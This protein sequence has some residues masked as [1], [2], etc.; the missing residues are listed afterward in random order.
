M[1]NFVPIFFLGFNINFPFFFGQ[2]QC[3]LPRPLVFTL[4]D[5]LVSFWWCST[6]PPSWN[7]ACLC[8]CDPHLQFSSISTNIYRSSVMC[9]T[10]GYHHSFMNSFINMH[11]VPTD[12]GYCASDWD[13][14]MNK[15]P[16]LVWEAAQSR[17]RD[18][19]HGPGRTGLQ[20]KCR[21][22][23]LWPSEKESAAS[24]QEGGIRWHS[25]VPGTH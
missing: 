18:K 10:L 2:I 21:L 12:P 19:K 8:F 4:L 5:L 1:T 13:T 3:F 15:M 9:Q 6:N 25:T 16:S 14:K 11:W 22:R 17:D 20:Q 23:G 24:L 7:S